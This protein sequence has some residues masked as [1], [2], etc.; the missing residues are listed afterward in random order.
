MSTSGD[1]TILTV[2]TGN[3]C[4]SPAAERLIQRRWVDGAPGMRVASVGTDAVVGA[5][6]QISMAHLLEQSGAYSG[7]F[8]AHNLTPEAL[9]AADLVLGMTRRHRAAVASLNPVVLPRTFTL[10]E[11]ARLVVEGQAGFTPSPDRSDDLRRL[12]KLAAGQRGPVGDPVSD[13]IADPYGGDLDGYIRAFDQIA[14]A[15]TA[16]A[17]VLDGVESTLAQRDDLSTRRRHPRRQRRRR[18]FSDGS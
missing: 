11:F 8:A 18:L 14:A 7:E 9:D 10:N 15:V 13:D 6:I 3:I 12:V 1:F 17:E 2:C 5:P 4:R 16:V